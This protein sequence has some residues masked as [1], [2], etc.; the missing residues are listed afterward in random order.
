MNRA[1]RGWTSMAKGIR[2]AVENPLLEALLGAVQEH[3]DWDRPPADSPFSEL[4]YQYEHRDYRLYDR[5]AEVAADAENESSANPL[6]QALRRA[7]QAHSQWW[8]GTDV[9][10]GGD[11]YASAQYA[12]D[13]ELYDAARQIR[14]EA[15]RA[16]EDP[17]I[18]LEPE[19][20][21]AVVTGKSTVLLMPAE[22][23]AAGEYLPTY[24]AIGGGKGGTYA[25][26]RPADK[27]AGRT[28][29]VIPHRRLRILSVILMR[30]GDICDAD[31]RLAGFRD[32]PELVEYGTALHGHFPFEKEIWRYE[33]E[34][35]S[36]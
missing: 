4:I 34:V 30:V 29:C 17:G 33:F 14:W 32:I 11:D 16:A 9:G 18:C 25:L 8:F 23:D 26:I 10:R 22:F 31:A 2:I 7:I 5:A 15:L 35:I 1:I 6:L 13:I 12:R 21:K 20:L 36:S 28:A 24:H 19:R 3:A 27:E